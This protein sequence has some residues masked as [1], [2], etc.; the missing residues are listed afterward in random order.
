MCVRIETN[1]IGLKY[2]I[3]GKGQ[4]FQKIRRH[5]LSGHCMF[6]LHGGACVQEYTLVK[7]EECT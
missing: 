1:C 3:L 7:V 4:V 2:V 6:I 5:R